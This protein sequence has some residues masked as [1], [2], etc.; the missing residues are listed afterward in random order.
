MDPMKKQN[1]ENKILVVDDQRGIRTLLFEVFKNTQYKVFLAK[2]H[3]EA[4]QVASKEKPDLAIIDIR[5]SSENGIA[6]FKNLKKKF[7]DLKAIMMTAYGEED[8]VEGMGKNEAYNFIFK[9]FDILELKAMVE[10]IFDNR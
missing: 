9:P 2:D 4:M 5:L 6:T 3:Q 8:V 1:K 10:K 7:P